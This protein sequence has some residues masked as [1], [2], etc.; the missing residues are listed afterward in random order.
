MLRFLISLEAIM[1]LRLLGVGSAAAVLA[2][3]LGSG[4]ATVGGF[5]QQPPSSTLTIRAALDQQE[6]HLQSG[7]A[8][9]EGAVDISGTRD[10]RPLTGN[11]YLEMTGYGGRAMVEMLGR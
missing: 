8:Y 4:V 10:G 7:L 6:M 1:H 11:G 2:L 5:A 3:A 9:W